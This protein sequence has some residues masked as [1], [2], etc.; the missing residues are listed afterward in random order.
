MLKVG[1]TRRTFAFRFTAWHQSARRRLPN[2]SKGKE[3]VIEHLEHYR[4]SGS[5]LPA[6]SRPSNANRGLRPEELT[7][8]CPRMARIDANEPEWE[9]CPR[10]TR[11]GRKDSTR[12]ILAF[13]RSLLASDQ[14]VVRGVS[15]DRLQA[16]SYKIPR[17]PDSDSRKF[18]PYAGR[19]LK[20]SAFSPQ[21]SARASRAPYSS[22][23]FGSRCCTMSSCKVARKT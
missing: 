21:P 10:K 16:S 8:R 12:R 23:R 3:R 20:R 18:A 13:C 11:N 5:K 15:P 1:T 6:L 4:V 7:R 14:D 9:V 22:S 17:I 2:Y 19:G